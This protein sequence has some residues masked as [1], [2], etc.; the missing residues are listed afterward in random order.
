MADDHFRIKLNS[1]ISFS[2]HATC[3]AVIEWK[4]IRSYLIEESLTWIASNPMASIMP[5]NQV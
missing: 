4:F 5:C 3:F 2:A 1:G